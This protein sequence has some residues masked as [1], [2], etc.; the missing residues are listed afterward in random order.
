MAETKISAIN[1]Q[2]F[3]PLRGGGPARQPVAAVRDRD[4]RPCVAAWGMLA[5]MV[6]SAAGRCCRRA[7]I[8]R[9]SSIRRGNECE[10]TVDNACQC[11]SWRPRARK[12]I[13]PTLCAFALQRRVVRDQRGSTPIS[14]LDP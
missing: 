13:A 11:D 2:P 4:A 7:F 14:L 5:G 6:S 8:D 10:E 1:A 12:G 9:H 3:P